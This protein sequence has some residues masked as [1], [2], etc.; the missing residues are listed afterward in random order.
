VQF[1][2]DTF[3]E[4]VATPAITD[5]VRLLPVFEHRKFLLQ[6]LRGAQAAQG[7]GIFG[8]APAAPAGGGLFSGGAPAGVPAP[9]A[10]P[11]LFGSPA[12]APLPDYDDDLGE[13]LLINSGQSA[14]LRPHG[15]VEA[16]H[17]VERKWWCRLLA[18]LLLLLLL[19]VVGVVMKQGHPPT[20]CTGASSRDLHLDQCVAYQNFFDKTGGPGW[21]YC[22]NSKLDPC[23]CF[24]VDCI[25][26]DITM[27]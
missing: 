3:G 10:V 8:G 6:A 22:N 1:L 19:V 17:R 2:N 27:M 16:V 9:A 11:G 21:T 26:D 5:L 4:A 15:W 18:G 13:K 25:D 12:P 7:G 24:Q 23:S 20:P 14:A